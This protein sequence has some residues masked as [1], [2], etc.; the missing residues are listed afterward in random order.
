MGGAIADAVRD[1]LLNVRVQLAG[2]ER[3]LWAGNGNKFHLRLLADLMETV[4]S[5]DE[6]MAKGEVE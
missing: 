2:I 3:M 6:A 1:R 4:N 5:L